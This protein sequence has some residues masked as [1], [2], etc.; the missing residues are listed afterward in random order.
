[1]SKVEQSPLWERYKSLME[2]VRGD[3]GTIVGAI[4]P[5]E[6]NVRIMCPFGMGNIMQHL[7]Q[8]YYVMLTDEDK[9]KH[10]PRKKRRIGD[11]QQTIKTTARHMT[12]EVMATA[13]AM[14]SMPLSIAQ[15]P[16]IATAMKKD[17]RSCRPERQ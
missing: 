15:N 1:M 3:D 9:A 5:H 8:F 2:P 6:N 12:A 4:F 13:C 16:G 7:V 14:G 10:R 17:A 11:G